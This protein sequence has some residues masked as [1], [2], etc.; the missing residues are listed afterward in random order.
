MN[1]SSTRLPISAVLITLNEEQNIARA[2]SSLKWAAEVVIYDSGSKDKTVEIAQKLGAKVIQ[3]PWLGFGPSKRKATSEAS[4]DWVL[5]LDADE[6]VPEALAAE[7]QKKFSELQPD[8]AYQIPRLS[9]YLGRWIRHG[10]WYPDR[11]TRL[12]NRKHS[13][14]NT[15]EIHEKVESPKLDRLHQHFH[16][17]V[18]KDIEHQVH[19]NNRYS[20]LQAL[21]MQ[22]RRKS[23]SWF[24][25]FTKPCVKFVECYIW[26]LGF[27]DGWAGYFIARSAAY[28]VFLKW[29][30]LREF[31]IQDVKS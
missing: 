12:F 4:H 1:S 26:K 28:S 29:S 27:L 10:G 9:R 31:S 21:E 20:S 16:H 22:K 7:I 18:F 25:F 5:S 8:T 2:L 19:T 24:H 17:Y 11:Q 3:G 23:F 13:N 6:E 15:A 30:K 14:W